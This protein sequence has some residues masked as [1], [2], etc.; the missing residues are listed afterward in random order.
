MVLSSNNNTSYSTE[1][2]LLLAVTTMLYHN[3]QTAFD[4]SCSIKTNRSSSR[5]LFRQDK[6]KTHEITLILK[7]APIDVWIKSVYILEK[8]WEKSCVTSY[9]MLLCQ[10][11]CGVQAN[12][13]E[14]EC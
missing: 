11:C 12:E 4:P 1:I 8:L 10:R 7:W 2:T 5:I 14:G 9:V 6:D 3:C 13:G